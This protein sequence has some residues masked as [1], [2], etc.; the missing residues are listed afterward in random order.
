MY[1]HLC[2]IAASQALP[3][4][5]VQGVWYCSQADFFFFLSLA[6]GFAFGKIKRQPRRALQWQFLEHPR[7][8]LG[9]FLHGGLLPAESQTSF[10]Q[11]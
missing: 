8:L 5:G 6:Y 7:V 4:A 11:Q 2:R 10:V 1:P 3:S 9:L